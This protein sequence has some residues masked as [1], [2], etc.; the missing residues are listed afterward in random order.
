[1]ADR[2]LHTLAVAAV[3]AALGSRILEV[4]PGEYQT[5]VHEFSDARSKI[6]GWDMEVFE[7]ARRRG[8][9]I[10]LPEVKLIVNFKDVRA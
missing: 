9:P 5:V 4:T 1:M 2:D 10:P 8:V 7:L 3:D 6:S